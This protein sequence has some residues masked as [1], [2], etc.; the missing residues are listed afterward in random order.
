MPTTRDPGEG[1]EG[2]D[3]VLADD[4]ILSSVE[5]FSLMRA[6]LAAVESLA[7]LA[8]AASDVGRR[9]PGLSKDL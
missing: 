5:F 1:G 9:S 3:G 6:T 2:A 7:A 4:D 8:R